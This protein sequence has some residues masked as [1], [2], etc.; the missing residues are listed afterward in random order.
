MKE[1]ILIRN[2]IKESNY[3]S[4]RTKD[5][6]I[7]S[8]RN[9]PIIYDE[10][11]SIRSTQKYHNNPNINSKAK[12]IKPQ[13]KTTRNSYIAKTRTITIKHAQIASISLITLATLL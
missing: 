9:T 7:K 1:V 2:N 10:E 11:T 5:L 8:Y 13:K 4:G 12:I 3:T 6:P